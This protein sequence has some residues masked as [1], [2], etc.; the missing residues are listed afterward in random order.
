MPGLLTRIAALRPKRRRTLIIAIDG[1]GG[2]GKSTLAGAL[3]SGSGG[4]I[5]VRTDDFARPNVPGWEW[6]RM[7]TQVLDPLDRD[8]PGKYQRHDWNSGSLAEWHSVPVGGI[9]IVE[10]ISSMRTE[11]GPYWDLA[12]WVTCSYERRLARGIARDGE[13]KRSQW[14]RVWMPQEDEY[15]AAQK[16]EQRADVVVSGEEPFQL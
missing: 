6:K 11:L 4:F 1:Y 13:A 12:V 9:V 3:A 5:V 2:S 15:V 10:G 8:L 16:P 14:E 7:K